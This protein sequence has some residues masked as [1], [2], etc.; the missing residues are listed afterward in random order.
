M[1]GEVTE[2]WLSRKG[3]IRGLWELCIGICVIPWN[4]Q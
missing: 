2:D 3:E 1:A 4:C